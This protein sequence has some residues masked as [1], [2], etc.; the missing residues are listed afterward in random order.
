MASEGGIY[1]ALWRPEEIGITHAKQLVEPLRVALVA[2]LDDP[3]RFEA[4]NSPNGWGMFEHFEPFVRK[5]WRA[6]KQFPDA[7]IEVSR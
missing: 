5:Y 2:M 1:E 4:H 3:E 7:I 6:C